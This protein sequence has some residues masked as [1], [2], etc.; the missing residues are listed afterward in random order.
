M[1][2]LCIAQEHASLRIGEAA[3]IALVRHALAQESREVDYLGIILADSALV[4]ALNKR[5]RG[6]DYDTDVLSFPL[7]EGEA[8]DGEVYV[9]LDFAAARCA[10]FGASFEEEAHRYVLHGLLH[11]MGYDDADEAG[12]KTMR[13]LENRYLSDLA[14][15]SHDALHN[16]GTLH[17]VEMN[18]G[19]TVV[20]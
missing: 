19:N 10:E 18:A 16:L 12:R 15:A 7:G 13:S 2:N 1:D 3:L 5:Y 8:I 14:E 11:L 4:R 20:E 9:S 17:D 6:G